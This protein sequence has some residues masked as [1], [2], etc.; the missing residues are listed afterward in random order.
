MKLTT[1]PASE[2]QSDLWSRGEWKKFYVP[3][4]VSTVSIRIPL[5]SPAQAVEVF[6]AENIVPSLFKKFNLF[7][8]TLCAT[9]K[10]MCQIFHLKYL[11]LCPA[12][13]PAGPLNLH[14]S[15]SPLFFLFSTKQNIIFL[16]FLDLHQRATVSQLTSFI[17]IFDTFSQFIHFSKWKFSSIT[18]WQHFHTWFA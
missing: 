6:C 15:S 18:S 2:S 17:S 12:F 4:N 16:S 5:I 1:S 7:S 11:R 8:Q 3:F 10:T 14:F 9:R 13:T